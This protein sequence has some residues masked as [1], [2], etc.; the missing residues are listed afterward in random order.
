MKI[1]G[2]DFSC[3]S[4]AYA[5]IE[6]AGEPLCLYPKVIRT[7]YVEFET[8]PELEC[9]AENI[10]LD[11]APWFVVIEGLFLRHNPATLIKLANVQGVLKLCGQKFNQCE[12]LIV[13]PEQ[14]KRAVGVDPYRKPYRGSKPKEKKELVM[15]AVNA[16]FGVQCPNEHIADAMAVAWAAWELC[17]NHL[18][19][20]HSLFEG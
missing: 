15:R 17:L 5:V 1:I 6:E 9:E 4:F 16:L 18:K 20:P 8:L 12:P 10:L 2:F 11:V 7:N 3:S 13:T 19:E 14:A